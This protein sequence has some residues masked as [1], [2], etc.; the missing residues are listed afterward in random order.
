MT[1]Q[2]LALQ[3]I[4]ERLS[5]NPMAADELAAYIRDALDNDEGGTRIQRNGLH[6]ILFRL[7]TRPMT[8]PELKSFIQQL[9]N[10]P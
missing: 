4:L 8:N 2:Q 9:L 5:S 10:N 7:A 3:T 6:T 1:Q